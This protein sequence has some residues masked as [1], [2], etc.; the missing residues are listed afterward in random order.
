MADVLDRG[1]K[2]KKLA[3]KMARLLTAQQQGIIRLFGK[4]P[5]MDKLTLEFWRKQVNAMVPAITPEMEW[6]YLQQAEALSRSLPIGVDWGLVNEAAVSWAQRYT[7]DLVTGINQTSS[8]ALQTA[9]SSYFEQG[10]TIGDLESRIGS[11]YAPYRAQTIAVTEVTRAAAQG[12]LSITDELRKQ[13]VDMVAIWQ[14]NEDELVCP[15]CGPRNDK[16]RGDGW[17]EPPPAHP[18]CRCWLNHELPKA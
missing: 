2:E 1:K 16:K 10:W 7:F 9:V 15:I 12:E 8:R 17:S 6:I 11:I 4:T 13:G 14:T 5:G 3:R 18:N